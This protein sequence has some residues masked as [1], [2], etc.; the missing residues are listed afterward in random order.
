[1]YAA[2]WPTSSPP[3]PRASRVSTA[4]EWGLVDAVA[5]RSRYDD[6]VQARAL[7]RA[8]GSD[9]PTDV[10]GLVLTP[11]E[12]ELTGAGLAYSYVRVAIDRDV[13]LARLTM[14]GQA[15]RSQPTRTSWT[16]LRWLVARCPRARRCHP[17]AAP[18]RARDRHLGRCAPRVTPPRCWPPSTS[19]GTP[20]RLAGEGDPVW[21]GDAPSAASTCR[22]GRL[23]ALSSPGAASPAPSPS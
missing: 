17:L 5:P 10:S 3:G 4:V 8:A 2:I 1:M 6:L 22:P 16:L 15:V 12:R 13:G 14:R 19:C 9:R 18:Q 23:V 7:R 11:L 20:R 21:L